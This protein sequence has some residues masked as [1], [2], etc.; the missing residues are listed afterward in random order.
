MFGKDFYPTPDNVIEIMMA[1]IDITDKVILEPSAGKGNIVDWL[2]NNNAKEVLACENN[3]DLR[4]I[5]AGKCNVPE[6]DFFQL[7]AEEISHIDLIV[8]NPPFS[9]DEKHIL[10]AW[11]IAP[12]G[13]EIIALCNSE[14][15]NNKYSRNRA[16]L[17]EVIEMNG[18]SESLYDCFTE[19]ER[20]TGV[21]VSL[22]RLYKPSTGEMEFDGYFEMQEEEEQQENGIMTYNSIQEV[23]SRFVGAVKM[24]DD[25][26][27]ASKKINDL[28]V[29]ISD[30]LGITFGAYT[31]SH[32][33]QYNVITRDVFKKALQK[34]AW[35]TIFGKFNMNKYVTAKIMGD[36]N[37]FV[38]QQT[39]VPFTVKNIFKMIDLIVG[40]HAE[41]MDNVLAEAFDQICG[42]SSENSTAGEKWKTNSNYK[43]NQKFIVPYM[44]KNDIRWPN[45]VVDIGYNS[46]EEIDDII[47]ALCHLQGIDYNTTTRIDSFVRNRNMEWGLWY[48]WGFF[49]IRGYKKGT[50]HFKFADLKVWERFNR[51]VA[52]IKG[53]QL[54]RKTDNKTKGTERTK[55]NQMEVCEF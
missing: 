27:L 50:M 7:K 16:I 30:G 5:V 12:G 28:K 33:Q 44:C 35:R 41:R 54:P 10:H 22:V 18:S 20:E 11:E 23:V 8:M 38:E 49:E 37:K 2:Q 45:P 14:T 13:C 15:L 39:A 32:G 19:A 29:P 48:S 42:Y 4:M 25:V 26:M 21:H 55:S 17:R 51:R 53:W 9:A 36:I 31:G 47:K 40:T 1:N 6:S 24:F 46:R 34:S 3:D 52:E 43:V